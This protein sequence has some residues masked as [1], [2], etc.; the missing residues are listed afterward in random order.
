M[1]RQEGAVA[2]RKSVMNKKCLVAL[3]AHPDDAEL[4]MGGTLARFAHAGC[5]THI[6][7]ASIPDQREK[8]L[9]E[10]RRGAEILGAQ[11]HF[12]ER[13]GLWQVEDI[14]VYELVRAFDGIIRELAPNMI[15]THWDEDTHYDHR[16]VSMAAL[17]CCRRMDIDFYMCEQP[18][19]C[20]PTARPFDLNTFVDVSDF[21]EQRLASINAHGSQIA[22]RGY[23]EHVLVRARFYGNRLGCQYA[24]AFRCVFQ[25]LRF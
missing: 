19:L 22:T 1:S 12:I 9:V 7:V 10:A 11:L 23:D 17:A 21:M 6:V 13:E 24:E 16:V 25:R 15:F 8:R 2:P 14:P 18:N 20:A 4:C 3:M 5:E